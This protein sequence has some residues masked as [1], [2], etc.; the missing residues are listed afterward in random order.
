MVSGSAKGWVQTGSRTESSPGLGKNK[1]DRKREGLLSPGTA[2]SADLAGNV[3]VRIVRRS[4]RSRSVA[5]SAGAVHTGI[6]GAN[7]PRVD[8]RIGI[9]VTRRLPLKIAK[10]AAAYWQGPGLPRVGRAD[11]SIRNTAYADCGGVGCSP[12]G[13]LRMTRVS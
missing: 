5:I 11:L 6:L 12:P 10:R 7:E 8:R 3:V 13:L 1:S 2:R 4:G 9:D